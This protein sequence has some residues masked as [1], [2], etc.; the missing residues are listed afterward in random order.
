MT[1]ILRLLRWV[2]RGLM[3]LFALGVAALVWYTHTDGFREFARQKLLALA[4]D[5]VRGKISIAKLAGSVW[6][7]LILNDVVVA[8]DQAEIVRIPRLQIDY[9]WVP[10]L[11][12]RF[13]ILRLE[14]FEP[15]VSLIERQGGVWNIVEALSSRE[16]QTETPGLV[17]ALNYL[18]V[19][20]ASVDIRLSGT[21][22]NSFRLTELNL[23]GSANVYATD[24]V[25]ELR[26]VSSRVLGA[27]LP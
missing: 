15:R 20:E 10:L 6:G 24:L 8:D 23:D 18:V 12:G 16:P 5:S 2:S 25:V 26:E 13:Q 14:A 9:S 17:V 19:R 21:A 1:I 7:H 4:N 3:L 11:W 27:G 22:Y